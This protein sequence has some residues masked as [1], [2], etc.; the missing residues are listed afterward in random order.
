MHI[1][2]DHR[3]IEFYNYIKQL[4]QCFFRYWSFVSASRTKP[5]VSELRRF[6]PQRV[7]CPR[8]FDMTDASDICLG[9]KPSLPVLP[10]NTSIIIQR[11][12]DETMRKPIGKRDRESK[13]QGLLDKQRDP[14]SLTFMHSLRKPL[15]HI[16]S[17]CLVH[18]LLSSGS[19]LSFGSIRPSYCGIVWSRLPYPRKVSRPTFCPGRHIIAPQTSLPVHNLPR[20]ITKQL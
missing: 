12:W 18:F 11:Q 16:L 20:P 13:K 17:R 3:R 15:T 2:F 1:F 6:S 7:S 19:N 14:I 8:Y 5:F 10:T 9:L 4:T